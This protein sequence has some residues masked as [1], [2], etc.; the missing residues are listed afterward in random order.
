MRNTT[1]WL[2]EQLGKNM[3]FMK[4]RL[5]TLRKTLQIK[6]WSATEITQKPIK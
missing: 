5:Q 6:H 4:T 2:V 1:G 3:L